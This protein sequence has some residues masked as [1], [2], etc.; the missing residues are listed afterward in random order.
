L[1]QPAGVYYGLKPCRNKRAPV[2]LSGIPCSSFGLTVFE[3]A[4][5][6]S[7]ARET[8]D[9]AV[10]Y[11]YDAMQIGKD[12]LFQ[13]SGGSRSPWCLYLHIYALNLSAIIDCLAIAISSV[14]SG[15]RGI[16]CFQRSLTP[17]QFL[18]SLYAGTQMSKML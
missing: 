15:R 6:A 4:Y 13:T 2:R 3:I 8:A 9:E 10:S 17:S 1:R 16:R 11:L 5:D 12:K 18:F 14:S 7:T